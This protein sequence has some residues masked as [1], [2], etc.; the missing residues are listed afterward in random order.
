MSLLQKNSGHCSNSNSS[1]INFSPRYRKY[2][3]K[4]YIQGLIRAIENI[5]SRIP[6]KELSIQFD[7]ALEFGV[8]EG[9]VQPW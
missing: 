7:I 5:Q 1:S 9:F 2:L 8:L 4:P 6:H 3:E